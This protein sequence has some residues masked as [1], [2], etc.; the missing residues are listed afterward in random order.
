MTFRTRVEWLVRVVVSLV[1]GLCLMAPSVGAADSFKL[2]FPIMRRIHPLYPAA[3]HLLPIDNAGGAP[4]YLVRWDAAARAAIYELEEQWQGGDWFL[5][6]AGDSV[7]VGLTNRPAG[8]YAYRVRGRNGL[9]YGPWSNL[10]GAH[11]AGT[12]PGTISTPSSSSVN[13]GGKALVKI[14]NDCPYALHVEF[15]G[16]SPGRMDLAKCDVCSVYSFIGPFICPT[17]NRPVQETPRDPGPYRVTVWVDQPGINPWVGFWQLAQN[18]RYTSCF[19]IVRRWAALGADPAWD[20]LPAA[21][22]D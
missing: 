12:P 11:V 17:T 13:A 7:Q 4:D 10:Q 5:V 2:Y 15:A 19:Y 18:R 22:G 20:L 1:F 3:P 9:G 6:Y 8:N 21:C 16:P 14:I